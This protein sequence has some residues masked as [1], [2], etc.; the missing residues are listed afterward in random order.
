[1]AAMTLQK[2]LICKLPPDK[3]CEL[4]RCGNKVVFQSLLIVVDIVCG[5]ILHH[6]TEECEFCS[7]INTVDR[8]LSHE[9]YSLWLE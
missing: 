2:I 5:K 3:Y 7:K 4:F 9:C 6:P 8:V 1:M